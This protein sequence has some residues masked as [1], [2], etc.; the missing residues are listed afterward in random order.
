VPAP[1]GLYL[2]IPFCRR[3][4]LYC[5]FV[6]F[7]GEE[8]LWQGYRDV[9]LGQVARL[10][11]WPGEPLQPRTLYV[12]GGTP[13]LWPASWLAQL[14]SAARAVG[15]QPEAEMTIEANPGTVDL[16][17]LAALREAGF[18]RLSLG[19]QSASDAALRLLGRI[20]TFAEAE[21]AVTWARQAGFDNLSLDLIYGLPGQ[22]LADWGR[23]LQRTVELGSEHLSAYALSL[24]AGTP[25]AEAVAAGELP[26]PDPDLQADMYELAEEALDAAG[27]VHYEISNWARRSHDG[28]LLSCQHNLIYWRN[29]PY[30]GLGAGAHSFLFGQR[31]AYTGD[32]RAYI[33]AGPAQAPAF[34]ESIPPDLEMAETAILGL[35]LVEGLERQRFRDRFG[36]DPCERFG[37]VVAWAQE[38]GLLEVTPAVMRLTRRGRLLSDELFQRLLPD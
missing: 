10:P 35:R 27:F 15:L 23:G 22:S 16:A 11:T 32:L 19:V 7:A 28:R 17:G 31:F 38:Q 20:H 18:N 8:G 37:P 2:H 34:V 5:D 9:L 13:S 12:G 14:A 30:L 33:G 3:K 36:Q 25:L 24:E 26:A 1:V 29:E 6:S 21:L 4:C